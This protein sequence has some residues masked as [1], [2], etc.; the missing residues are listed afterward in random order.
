MHSGPRDRG[1]KSLAR[2]IFFTM[3]AFATVAM[4]VFGIATTSVFYY[5]YEHDAEDRIVQQVRQVAVQ[6]NGRDSDKAGSYLSSAPW[7]SLRC[8]LIDSDGKVLF[9]SEADPSTMENHSDR[10]EFQEAEE[11]GEAVSVRYS[12]TL[13][14]DTVYAAV[15]LDNGSVVRLS[16]S[17][18]SLLSFLGDML[19]PLVAAAAA[20][21]LISFA[22][23]RYLTKKIMRP[24]DEL[25]VSQPLSNEAYG[26]MQPLLQRID[27]QQNQL[28]RQNRELEAAVE[29]RREFSANVSHEMKTP[30]QVIG[31]YSEL[32]QAGMVSDE[33]TRKFAGIIHSEAKNMRA[34]IDDVLTL[35]RLDESALGQS[36]LTDVDLRWLCEQ[37]ADRLEKVAEDRQVAIDLHPCEHPVCVRGSELL[38][39][40]MLYNLVD[41]AVRYNH[42]G[43]SVSVSFYERPDPAGARAVICVQDTGQ[44]I[45]PD[46]R[47]RV[48]ERF[49]RLEAGRSRET[50]GTGLGLAIVKHVAQRYD[51]TV[52][53]DDAPGGGSIFTV[54]LPAAQTS[55]SDSPQ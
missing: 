8:T 10:K 38:L 14:V 52:K 49:F 43:G 2:R 35:S 6:L 29:T 11:S 12:E 47:Q 27:E 15:R 30:L 54:D 4:V 46:M 28:K 53:I 48:F 22:L 39:Q 18:R 51:G 26:E 19:P 42:P 1:K 41:N 23:S 20:I 45:P 9:D 31:G 17:R 33:D 16:E 36:E 44:G 7:S 21:I 50:G 32:I 40:E 25:D 13:G 24:I 34:L 5:S 55:A 3:A 37:V